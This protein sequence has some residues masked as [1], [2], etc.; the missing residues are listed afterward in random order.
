MGFLAK[1]STEHRR[2]VLITLALLTLGALLYGRNAARSLVAGGFDDPNS[3]SS[4]A[5]ALL[6]ERF[7]L[8][9]PDVVVA[10]SHPSLKVQDPKFAALLTPALEAL[11]ALPGIERV[12]TP[13]GPQPDA[14]V[15]NDGSIALVSVRFVER[16]HLAE[17]RYDQV[18]PA[19]KVRG[20]NSWLGGAIPGARQA[21]E[22]AEAD[23][24]RAELIT[25][26][27]VAVMLV[28]FFRGV[29]VALLPMLVGG[30]AVASALACIRL[31]THVTDVSIFA[32][33][34]VTF[35]GLGVAIDYSLFMTARFRDELAS[36]ASVQR[37]VEHTLQTSGR[38]IAYS[39]AAVAVSMLALA[40]FPMMLLRSIAFAG[41]LVVLM[42]LVGALVLLPALL[43]LLGP[44]IEWL[45]IGRARVHEHGNRFWQLV[46][47]GV[48]RRPLLVTLG[49]TALLLVL[50]AP[51][52]R[53]QPAVAGASA[54]PEEAEARH[55]AELLDSGRFPAAAAAPV[56]V[57]ASLPAPVLSGGSLR[58]LEAYATD[59]RKLPHVK[60]VE[61]V[62]G[63]SEGMSAQQLSAA[64]G[65]PAADTLRAR[66]APIVRERDTA[67]RVVLDVDPQSDQAEAAIHT[68]RKLQPAG[69]TTL[70]T[71]P[72]ARLADLKH[73]LF[74]RLPWAFGLIGV[75]TF[76][77]L[78]LA[79]G[80]VVM[81]LKAILMNVL[82]LTASF[83]ALV[84]I[85]QDGRLE[86]LLDFRSPGHI[87]ITVPVVM[88][89]VVFGLAM[90]YELFL[91]SRIREAYDHGCDT[92]TSVSR[93]LLRTAQLI[94][95]A[96]LLLVGVLVGFITA[97]MLLVKEMG[98][99]MAIAVIVD[100]TIVRALLVPASMQLL[101]AYNWW[102]PPRLLAWWQRL[103]LAVDESE[104]EPEPEPDAGRTSHHPARAFS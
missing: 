35:V 73:A 17:Q 64:L 85:F 5:D 9:T 22:A 27:L 41:S 50:G 43:A 76:V 71:S 69:M 3:E 44:R 10:Y 103:H 46:A 38:T 91:L 8:G 81:P 104:P 92:R 30:F 54:L 99:G 62:V 42:S 19:L 90:D 102:A 21:V 24:V 18:L 72:A 101:G 60:R 78:F 47:E 79:F 11:R 12:S 83:G 86:W 89:A 98:V 16:G 20:L 7:G 40:I 37:A 33:N 52:L 15:S 58:S 56:L 45:R 70:V 80:S 49:V 61:A 31:L 1:L 67:L 23:L 34:I 88:F 48:M 66:F 14:I 82:S 77:V 39:G 36:G 51:F 26:P 57:L 59:L 25:L 13:Y 32:M 53:V 68:I 93:G 94:S 29:V 2:S 87:E 74:A 95:R 65:S 6:E 28:V 63:G 55:V 100:A 96:A 75:A 84:W 97:D 4:R